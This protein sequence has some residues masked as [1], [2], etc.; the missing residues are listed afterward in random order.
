MTSIERIWNVLQSVHHVI[1]NNI[2]GDLVEIGVWKGGLIMAMALK[3]QQMGIFRRIHAYD[4]F[5]GMTAP[6]NMD[7]DLDDQRAE[8]ILSSVMCCSRRE[9]TEKNIA[10]TNYQGEIVFHQGN[11][12]NTKTSDIPKTIA[13]LRLDTDWYELTKYEL[14][15]FEPRVSEQGRIIIDDYGHWKGC[16]LAVDEWM[17]ARGEAASVLYKIDY[18]G[19]WWQ[20]NTIQGP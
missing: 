19:I 8:D 9:E 16:K 3:C 18:T 6:G 5:E 17:H 2:P 15:Y 7:I 4:T 13:L 11:I 10:K 20:K 12:L 14:D 1:T